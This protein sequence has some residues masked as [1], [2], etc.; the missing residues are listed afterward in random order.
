M[1]P[2]SRTCPVPVSPISHPAHGLQKIQ[3]VAAFQVLMVE[4]SLI[5]GLQYQGLLISIQPGPQ[6]LFQTYVQA[7]NF[8]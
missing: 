2:P 5:F 8:C 1:V 7:F 3:A 4:V 6:T